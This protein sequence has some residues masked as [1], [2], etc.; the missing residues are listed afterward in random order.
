MKIAI[1]GEGL[2]CMG[3]ANRVLK[4]LGEIYPEAD[5]FVLFGDKKLPSQEFTN[6]K[7][8]YSF[9]NKIPF[10]KKLYRY[11][12]FLWP[13]AVESFDLSEY[14]LVISSSYSVAHGAITSLNTKHVAYVH[15]PMRYA[16]DLKD[17]YFSKKNFGILRRWIIHP[18]LTYLRAWDVA[19]SARA[20]MILANSS[21]VKKRIEKYWDREVDAVVNPPVDLYRG[22]II[23]QREEYF[24]VGA[25]FE[26]N[27]YGEFLFDIAV[28]LDF[29]LKVIGTGGSYP[30]LK[31]KYSRYSQ[32]EFLGRISDD[33]KYDVLSKAKGYIM[34]GIE[35]F[36]IFPVEALSCGTP[37]LASNVGGAL[38]YLEEG[39]NGLFFKFGSKEDFEKKFEIFDKKKWDYIRVSK[40]SKKFEER[41]FKETFERFCK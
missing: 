7:V 18:L 10:I 38:D 30:K 24:V 26:P 1:I 14:D 31:K 22:K 41:I 37:V 32:I 12:Y 17:V 36:G 29:D 11:T 9:L 13:L 16:W 5:I 33:E 39:V 6:H 15:T 2:W 8:H 23:K 19:A 28:D 40:T 4:S 27:K 34:P 21:F 35:E 20:D 3:G 25:P